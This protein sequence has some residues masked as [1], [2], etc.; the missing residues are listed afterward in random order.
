[1]RVVKP[2]AKG[3]DVHVDA[4]FHAQLLS[5]RAGAVRIDLPYIGKM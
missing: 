3:L 5:V 1:M 2:A 4:C